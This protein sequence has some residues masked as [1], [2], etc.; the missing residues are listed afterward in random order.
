MENFCIDRQASD[1]NIIRLNNITQK[2]FNSYNF[3]FMM[4]L[5]QSC[6]EEDIVWLTKTS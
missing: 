4:P 2:L 1:D 5:I 3:Y 6:I